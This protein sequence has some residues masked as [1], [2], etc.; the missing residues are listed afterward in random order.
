L[1]VRKNSSGSSSRFERR[2]RRHYREP[3]TTRAGRGRR[4]RRSSHRRGLSCRR[5]SAL[6]QVTTSAL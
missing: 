1:C 6:E 3:R 5:P 4:I 2:R